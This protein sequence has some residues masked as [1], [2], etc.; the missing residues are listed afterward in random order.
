MIRLNEIIPEIQKF[1]QENMV[2]DML[3]G[4]SHV[5][6]VLKYASIVNKEI[7]GNWDVIQSAIFLHDIGHKL[8][9]EKH[10]E[11]SA[12]MAESFLISKK[13]DQEIISN[14]T[15]SILTHSRQFSKEKPTSPEAKVLY[16]ADGMD[17]FGP[18]GLMRAILACTLK[19]KTF[20]CILKKLEWRL[21]QKKYFNSKA[22]KIFVQENSTLIEN[23]LF[24]LKKQLEF[25]KEIKV[26]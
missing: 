1:G 18:I 12:E 26:L 5:E 15:H 23:Y 3:H 11:I 19:N 20:E 21:E 10:H 9:R 6:R 17:L 24:R 2:Q 22:A 13:I 7:R 8:N 14:I 25:I 16:D 4:W